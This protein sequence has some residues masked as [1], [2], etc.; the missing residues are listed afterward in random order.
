MFSFKSSILIRLGDFNSLKIYFFIYFLNLQK[1]LSLI[2]LVT[3]IYV[4]INNIFWQ[5]Y[6]VWWKNVSIMKSISPI[7][8]GI[9]RLR[10]WNEHF[11]RYSKYAKLFLIYVILHGLHGFL[12]IKAVLRKNSYFPKIVKIDSSELY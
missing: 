2:K 8:Y 9:I 5:L 3:E 7:K 10:Y 6:W 12:C 4:K 1:I 11:I